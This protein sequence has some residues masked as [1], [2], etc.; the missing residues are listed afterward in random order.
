MR[1]RFKAAIFVLAMWPCLLS[2]QAPLGAAVGEPDSLTNND[3]VKMVRVKLGD[4]II[5]SKIK[6]SPCNFDTSVD[7]LVKLKE[8]GVSDTVI[9]TMQDAQAAAKAAEST[10][11]QPSEPQ[12]DSPPMT[13]TG[14]PAP[15]SYAAAFHDGKPAL[16]FHGDPSMEIAVDLVDHDGE[17]ALRLPVEHSHIRVAC[18]TQGCDTCAGYLYI[19][20]SRL[21]YDPVDAPKFQQEAFQLSRSDIKSARVIQEHKIGIWTSKRKYLFVALFD[22][23]I[24]RRVFGGESAAPLY[25][26][27]GRSLNDF[28]STLREAEALTASLA[29]RP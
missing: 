26:F 24:G 9:Q 28:D 7:A 3:I 11:A 17:R 1:R 21:S 10:P 29:R 27:I 23:D 8:A 22:S 5:I 18:N 14:N 25:Q 15:G 4:G 20:H 19:S 13:H 16:I 12:P 2:A 6:A